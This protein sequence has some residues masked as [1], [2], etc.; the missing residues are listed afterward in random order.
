MLVQKIFFLEDVAKNQVSHDHRFKWSFPP[1]RSPIL[2]AIFPP[3]L[4]K[5]GLRSIVMKF[6]PHI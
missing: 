1:Q 6:T 2:Q 4:G 3:T 5:L